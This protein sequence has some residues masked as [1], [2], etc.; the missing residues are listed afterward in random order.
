MSEK[1]SDSF[2]D[3]ENNKSIKQLLE[4]TRCLE[5]IY[6][7]AEFIQEFIDEISTDP[8]FKLW[9]GYMAMV[10]TLF[11]Y[12]RADREGNW[13]LHLESFAVILPWITVYDHHNYAKWGSVYLTE[14]MNLEKTA[15]S[16]FGE[17]L[18]GNFG[19][20]WTKGTFN[21]VSADHAT[22]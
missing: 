1:I 3:R 13:Q 12:V 20:R 16:V 11:N 5:Q 8:N 17:F 19:V 9:N 21:Q 7:T 14:I 2:K 15:S 4:A 6:N 18:K 10:E 22:E